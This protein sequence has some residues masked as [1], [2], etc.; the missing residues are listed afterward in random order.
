[1]HN[2]IRPWYASHAVKLCLL[3]LL[4]MIAMIAI[5]CQSMMVNPVIQETPVFYDGVDPIPA[6]LYAAVV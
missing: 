5:G 1:M 2:V 6:P 3:I 4:L